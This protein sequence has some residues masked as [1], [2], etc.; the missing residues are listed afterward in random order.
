VKRPMHRITALF[1]CA[2]AAVATFA[3]DLPVA[4]RPATPPP[5][6]TGEPPASSG[7]ALTAA[8]VGAWLDGYMP[9]TLKG[10]KIAGAEVV[11]VKDG[12]V[13][14]KKGYG[15]AD[16]AAKTPMDVDR[17]LMRIGSTSKLF[18]W[19]AVMQQ[20]EAGRID[21]DADINRYLDFHVP[22]RGRPVT[23]ND[24]MRHRGGFEEGLKDLMTDDPA[25][26]K[27]TERY[28]KE[29]RRPQLFPAG[30]VPAYSNY[31]TALAG[32]IV[33]RVSGEPFDTYIERHILSP[34]RMTRTTFRQP[35]PR[36][37]AAAMSKGYRQSDGP[38]TPFELVETAPAGSVSTTGADM[39]NFMIA[40]LQDG[41]F[42]AAQ[43]LRPDTAQ[44]MHTPAVQPEPGFDTLAHGF[45]R[46]HRNGQ[47]VIGHGGDTIVFH[48]DLNLLPQS[49][50]GIFVSF[51]SRGANDAVYGARERLF[52]QFMDRYYPVPPPVTPPAVPSAAADAAAL[53]GR[54][55]GSRRVETGFIGLFYLLQQEVVSADPDGTITLSSSP[56][57]RFREIA[58]GLWREVDGTRL[59]RVGEAE[60]RRAISD[61]ANPVAILQAAPL[62]RNSGL[63]LWIAGLS[64]LV[65]LATALFWPVGWWLRRRH[66]VAETLT[67]RP[68]LARRLTRIAAVADLLY[69]AA[70]YTVLA[71]ILQLRVEVYNS[72]LDA[73]IRALQIAAI[74]PLAGAGVGLWNLWLTARSGR[75]WGARVRAAL[76]AAALLGIAWIAWMG[77]LMSFNL[78]Y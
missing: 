45:F 38:P 30:A 17:T 27:T 42:G 47:L 69:L 77:K 49:N 57:A 34:L 40:H 72:A 13:L 46:G 24:L 74:V 44:A 3:Q 8:D 2:L 16:V 12:Q 53:A 29:N 21:L 6:T 36:G 15:L 65:L 64:C 48:T 23:M 58:P 10:G 39:A 76:V 20:V 43:I 60:S 11:V 1:A 18:T 19:T 4:P 35:L 22:A 54:Y 41:R 70:W 5:S 66:K 33:Q 7:P 68:S 67:G 59:L 62:A 14:F 9:G 55:E 61:S 71:P 78:N 51:N 73:P 56:D 25:R 32:Y 50:V 28:L 37:W 52:D 75:G 31:G 63:N 26:L